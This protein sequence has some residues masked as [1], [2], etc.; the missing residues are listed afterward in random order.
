MEEDKKSPCPLL[1][2]TNTVEETELVMEFLKNLRDAGPELQNL[3]ISPD[4]SLKEREEVRVLVMK[5]KN[6]NTSETRDYV[7]IVR[8]KQILRLRKTKDF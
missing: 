1:V 7:H 8:D 3:R 6:S 2:K 4:R 5:A